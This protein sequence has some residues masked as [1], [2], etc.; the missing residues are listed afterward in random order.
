MIVFR[1][2]GGAVPLSSYLKELIVDDPKIIGKGPLK[3]DYFSVACGALR[4]ALTEGQREVTIKKRSCDRRCQCIRE[5][6]EDYAKVKKLFLPQ[7]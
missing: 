6:K 3:A 5:Y 1:H 4:L 2:C 7:L